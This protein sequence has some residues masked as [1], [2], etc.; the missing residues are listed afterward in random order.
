LGS[1]NLP[2]FISQVE[3]YITDNE[4]KAVAAY[5]GSGGWLTE[6]E[7][8]REFERK[9]AEFVGSRYAVV[10]TSGTVALYLA[11]LACGVRNGKSVVV[12]DYTMIAT[13]NSIKWAGGDVILVDV[14][15]DTLCLDLD[16][17]KL[18]RN[19][20]SWLMSL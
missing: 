9:I 11:M 20:V 10:V 16:K 17:L 19:T 4:R 15:R 7:K 6:H 12:P 18:H 1:S 2:S 3:P 14:R 13:P 8:T 5:L